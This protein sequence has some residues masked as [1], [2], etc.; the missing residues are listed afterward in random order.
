MSK[1][2]KKM[3]L[4]ELSFIVATDNYSADLKNE[5]YA[6]I[7]RRFKNNGCNYHAFMEYEEE[8]ISKRGTNIDSYLIGPKPNGQLLMELQGDDFE[9]SFESRDGGK[10]LRENFGISE[11]ADFK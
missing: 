10:G 3:S 11:S 1:L 7:Q 2:M 5:A 6:E 8:A 9:G 4:S